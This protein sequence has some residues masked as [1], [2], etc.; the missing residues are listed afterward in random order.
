MCVLSRLR[1]GEMS[2][3]VLD[4]RLRGTKF[5]ELEV[6]SLINSPESTRMGFWSINPYVGC[7]FGCSY[8]YARYAH[9]YVVDR[10]HDSGR[11]D[12]DEFRDCQ[13]PE[14]LEAFEH[15]IFV[16]AR[17]SALVALERDLAKVR[18]RVAERGTQNIVI[19][20]ATDPYQPAERQYRVTRAVLARLA[21][22]RGHRIG[23]ITKSPLVIRDRE[24]LCAV[25]RRNHVSVYVSLI[26]TDVRVI[27]LFEERSPMPHTRLR[28]LARLSAA[29][30]RAGLIVAPILPGIT[31]SVD[32]IDSLMRAAKDA[33]AQFVYPSALRL[34]PATR[35]RF[36]P[37]V[38]KHFPELAQRY[39][40]AYRSSRNAPKQ[41]LEAVR[42]RFH[43]IASRYGIPDTGGEYEQPIAQRMD[44]QLRLL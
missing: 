31:D 7:E 37:I 24:L 27:K 13:E 14:G 33:D 6:K 43:H 15:R 35:E 40:I 5:I 23:L 39:Q 12:D 10:A 34:Y 18:K 28:A 19:G 41:Y 44:E 2:V 21:G 11:L 30:I 38:E 32:Q 20:T 3:T 4:Q 8:C 42:R 16:K 22:E 25:A 26:S 1:V 29:G 17:A 9:R 36:L